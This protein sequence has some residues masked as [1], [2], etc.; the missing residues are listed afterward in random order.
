MTDQLVVCNRLLIPLLESEPRR[1]LASL[2]PMALSA[3]CMMQGSPPCHW[4]S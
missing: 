1:Q 4:Q 3:G 2:T